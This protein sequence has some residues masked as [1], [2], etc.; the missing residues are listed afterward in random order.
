MQHYEFTLHFK[1]AGKDQDVSA[2]LNTLGEVGCTDTLV[3]LGATGRV[4]LQFNRDAKDALSAL[5]SGLKDAQK[6]LPHAVLTEAAPDMVG[7]TE[8]AELVKVSRQNLRKLM[9]THSD[10][11]PRPIHAGSTVIWHLADVLNWLTS[12]Q[13]YKI[14]ST[15]LEMAQLTKQVNLIKSSQ[16]IEPRVAKAF[17][18]I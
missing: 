11:F 17:G 13:H 5:Q 8:V 3:G 1:L 16:A 2:I 7:L 15:V 14:E 18:A 6:A 12:K 9:Q 4:A 10:S